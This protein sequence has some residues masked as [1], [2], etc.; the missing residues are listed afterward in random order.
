MPKWFWLGQ[1][2]CWFCDNRNNCSQCKANRAA[3]KHDK[4]LSKKR[5]K[6]ARYKEYD[7]E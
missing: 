4:S 3:S 2:G 5:D 1:D 7:D 6:V